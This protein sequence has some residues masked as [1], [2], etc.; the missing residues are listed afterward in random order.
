MATIND[1]YAN[2][3]RVI[4]HK[5]NDYD[6][7][8]LAQVS[9]AWSDL[10]DEGLTFPAK[11]LKEAWKKEA[12]QGAIAEPS[13]SAYRSCQKASQLAKRLPPNI[14]AFT[15]PSADDQERYQYV[16]SL[17]DFC[18]TLRKDV[19]DVIITYVSALYKDDKAFKPQISHHR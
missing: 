9:R 12:T 7:R 17:S 6:C 18:D 3:N 8:S 14:G 19:A 16:A 1:L 15:E 4:I 10:A 5:L 13:A 11:K 2:L